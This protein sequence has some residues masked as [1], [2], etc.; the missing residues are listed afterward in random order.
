MGS[1]HALA[2]QVVEFCGVG[3]QLQSDHCAH[4]S[5]LVLYSDIS[6]SQEHP[7]HGHMATWHVSGPEVLV[8][9][10]A[11]TCH[12]GVTSEVIILASITA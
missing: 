3:P 5:I 1:G 11:L 2:G 12:R 6:A 9:N 8:F 4:Y 10:R 7:P